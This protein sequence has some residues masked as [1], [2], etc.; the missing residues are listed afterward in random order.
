MLQMKC[1]RN[2][3]GVTLWDRMWNTTILEN[4]GELPVEDHLQKRRH[5][6]FGQALNQSII[7]R[8]NLCDADRVVGRDLQ[9]GGAPLRWC[10]LL[11]NA[12][13]D[14][15]NWTEVIQAKQSCESQ[16][17]SVNQPTTVS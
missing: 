7:P 6:W 15:T 3:L 9:V 1:L 4:T 10:D 8:G 14:M 5:Q 13:R 12:F 11:I 16:S 17:V 2:I